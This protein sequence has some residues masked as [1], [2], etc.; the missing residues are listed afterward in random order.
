VLPFEFVS[1]ADQFIERLEEL[2][3]GAEAVG[4]DGAAG[5]PALSALRPSSSTGAPK[6]GAPAMPAAAR[7]MRPPA[8]A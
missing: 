4:L 5:G 2:K 6:I 8:E 7:P 3:P 1:V